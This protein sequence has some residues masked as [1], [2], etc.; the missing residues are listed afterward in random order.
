MY[1]HSLSPYTQSILNTGGKFNESNSHRQLHFQET[2]GE[3]SDT[4]TAGGKLGVSNKTISKWENGKCMPDYSIIE[5]VCRELSV[6]LPELMD[7]EDAAEDSM[8]VYDD[9]QILD[10]LRRMQELE[11]Q[12]GILYGIILVVLGL[13]CNAMSATASGSEVQEFV[14]GLLM[15]LSVAEILAGIVIVGKSILKR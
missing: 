5:Q 3:K 12:K 4:G 15:G 10:L 2:Q 7:G 8:R 13:A 11:R 1:P 14:S 6:T 9:E